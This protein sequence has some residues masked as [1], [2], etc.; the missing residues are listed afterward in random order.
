MRIKVILFLVIMLLII[1]QGCESPVKRIDESK[2]NKNMSLLAQPGNKVL[3][4]SSKYLLNVSEIKDG[5]D[6]WTFSIEEAA[7]ETLIFHASEKFRIRDTLYILWDDY[8]QVWVYSGDVGTFIWSNE[9]NNWIKRAYADDV[10]GTNPP[11]LLKEL[12]PK[13]FK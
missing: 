4:P 2:G 9:E 13:Y 3:S 8:D 6:S 7:S 5:N 12:R 11:A 10:T 1:T